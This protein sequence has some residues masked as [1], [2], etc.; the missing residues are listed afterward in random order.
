MLS[1][2]AFRD[3][4]WTVEFMILPSMI[5]QKSRACDMFEKN[6]GGKNHEENGRAALLRVPANMEVSMSNERRSLTSSI[7]SASIR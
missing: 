1:D 4:A 6:D 5:L 7:A 3:G 2:S